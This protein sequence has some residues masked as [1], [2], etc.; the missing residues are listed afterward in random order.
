V[1]LS[2]VLL[3][4][5]EAPLRDLVTE[6][7]H[8]YGFDVVTAADGMEALDVLERLGPWDVLLVDDQMPRLTGRQFLKEARARGILTP[9]VFYSG[10]VAL[11]SD[12]KERL[13][14][15]RVLQKPTRLHELVAAIRLTIEESQLT[16]H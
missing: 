8:D 7:L 12:E 3:V 13:H 16:P 15:S 4:E 6:A 11:G 2:R 9:G 14:V 5:D 10:N 1:R